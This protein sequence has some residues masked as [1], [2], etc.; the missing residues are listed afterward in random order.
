[1]VSNEK[2][3]TVKDVKGIPSKFDKYFANISKSQIWRKILEP[4]L[5]L[6]KAAE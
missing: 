3:K 5:N 6:K 1:M 4:H 2:H